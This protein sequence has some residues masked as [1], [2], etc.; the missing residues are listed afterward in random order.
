MNEIFDSNE[1]TRIRENLSLSKTE[2]AQKLRVSRAS[3]HLWESGKAH[4]SPL[5]RD[6]LAIARYYMRSGKPVPHQF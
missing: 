6:K 2:F 4:P 5:V 3:V 1:I